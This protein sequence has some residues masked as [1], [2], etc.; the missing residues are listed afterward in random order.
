[1]GQNNKYQGI[2]QGGYKLLLHVCQGSL[3]SDQLPDLLPHSHVFLLQ[4]SDLGQ[5]VLDF[6][7]LLPR[8]LKEEEKKEKTQ[9]QKELM[10]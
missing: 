4:T 2:K 6:L 1:L 3:L 9:S 7:A 8:C 10:T 5:K